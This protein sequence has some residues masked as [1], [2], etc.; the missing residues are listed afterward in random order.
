MGMKGND[1]EEAKEE[2][3]NIWVVNRNYFNIVFVLLDKN[4]IKKIIEEDNFELGKE[5]YKVPVKI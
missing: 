5:I 1:K 3:Y 2:I 4:N